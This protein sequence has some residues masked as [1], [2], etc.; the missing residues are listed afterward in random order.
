METESYISYKEWAQVTME[1]DKS[2]DLQGELTSWTSRGADE[3][4]VHRLAGS[5]PRKKFPFESK[6]RKK[7][8]FQLEG[9]QEGGILSFVGERQPFCINQ[10]FDWSHEAHPHYEAQYA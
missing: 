1:V 10:A 9:S 8:M 5:K 3:I 6:G 4:L 2:Q 7:V